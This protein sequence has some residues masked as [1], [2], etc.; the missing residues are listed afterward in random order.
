MNNLKTL[1]IRSTLA[2]LACLPLGGCI[3]FSNE[4]SYE[5]GRRVSDATVGQIEMGKTRWHFLQAAF[6]DPTSRRTVKDIP[7]YEVWTYD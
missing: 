7:N 2:A 4:S 6:G 3:A 1:S 5:H